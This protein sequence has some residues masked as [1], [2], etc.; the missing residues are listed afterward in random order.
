MAEA[1]LRVVEDDVPSTHEKS[2][3][4]R[5]AEQSSLHGYTKGPAR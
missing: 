5:V 3:E 1:D 2:E 4:S